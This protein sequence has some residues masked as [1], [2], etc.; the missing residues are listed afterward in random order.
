[1]KRQIMATAIVVALSSGAVFA[2]SIVVEP[3]QRT[4]I[5]EY[6]VKQN[7][8]RVTVRERYRVGATVPPDV[9][10]TG[11]PQFASTDTITRMRAFILWTPRV[12]A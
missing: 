1:M 5:K 2:Q 12:A 4:R 3:E 6:V 9:E 10:L 8:P 7:V 11:V